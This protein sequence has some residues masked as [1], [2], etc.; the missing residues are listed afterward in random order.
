MRNKIRINLLNFFK[1]DTVY[2]YAI[3]LVAITLFLRKHSVNSI[4]II[5]LFVIWTLKKE[6]KKLYIIKKNKIIQLFIL[7]YI[8]FI[9]GAFYS[10]DFYEALK[11]LKLRLPIILFP[12]VFLTINFFSKRQTKKFKKVFISAAFLACLYC[13]FRIILKWIPT[14][15]PFIN[16]FKDYQ[17]SYSYITDYI[18]LPPTYFSYLL[19]ICLIFLFDLI[20]NSQSIKNKTIGVFTISYFIFFI[21]H[22]TSRIAL[23]GL[24]LLFFFLI[25][26]SLIKSKFK[27]AA[28]IIIFLFSGIFIASRFDFTVKRYKQVVNVFIPQKGVVHATGGYRVFSVKAFTQNFNKNP[29]FGV[30]LGD[31]Q[32][33]LDGYFDEIGFPHMKGYDYHNQYIQTIIELGL[34][35]FIVFLLV[36]IVPLRISIISRNKELFLFLIITMLFLFV[37]NMFIRHK[38]IVPYALFNALFLFMF[39]NSKFHINQ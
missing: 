1:G 31:G 6:Y 32:K 19:L 10:S 27:L 33:D 35:G 22:I 13:Q 38:G 30:G 9:V 23:V 25:I 3:I 36:F 14:K 20:K 24:I 16:L 15:K 28:I 17:F 5:T 4:A 29:V 7:F 8:T 34:V 18:D 21:I 39:S 37:E 11:L 2:F 12:V 26:K